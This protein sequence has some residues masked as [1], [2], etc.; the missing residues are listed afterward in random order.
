MSFPHPRSRRR[1]TLRRFTLRRFTLVELLIVIAII[2]VLSALLLPALQG[3]QIKKDIAIAKAQISS[4]NA[5]LVSY[6]SDVGR[7][8]RRS[9]RPSGTAL[10]GP[11]D[12]SYADDAVALYAALAT[13][14]TLATGGGP[15]SPYV[16]GWSPEHVGTFRGDLAQNA[17]SA[18]GSDG[19]VYVERISE[20]ERAGLSTLRIQRR[21]LPDS[22]QPLVFLDPWGN[23][24]H[25]REWA[26]VRSN[27]TDQMIT[28]P[29]PR[30]VRPPSDV[31]GPV[32]TAGVTDYPHAPNR[33]E[34][35]SNGPNGINE[36]GHPDSDDVVS[37][38]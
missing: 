34:I 10:P 20:T 13:R 12:A 7:Y 38:R 4:L 29:A 33:Y 30:T 9:A 2:A 1:F 26:S 5:A 35:W 11:E 22:T 21:H 16:D 36:F 3:V 32:I 14:P 31:S 37:W 25:Y 8:P 6:K 19:S 27:L 23:P 15:N 17:P 28:S 18:M 24:Y